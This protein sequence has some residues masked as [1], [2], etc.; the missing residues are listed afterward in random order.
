MATVARKG[1]TRSDPM[2]QAALV[3]KIKNN[4]LRP[5]KNAAYEQACTAIQELQALKSLKGIDAKV[6]EASRRELIQIVAE[7]RRALKVKKAK[8]RKHTRG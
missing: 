2:D 5:A 1:A 7:Y 8:R 3:E 4:K 6:L